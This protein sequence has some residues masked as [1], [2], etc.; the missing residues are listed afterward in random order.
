MS[1]TFN[2]LINKPL[3][4]REEEVTKYLFKRVIRYIDTSELTIK[5]KENKTRKDDLL[6]E[7][8]FVDFLEKKEFSEIFSLMEK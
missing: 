3:S 5:N 4:R 2:E 6:F 8:Y 1:A 7:N